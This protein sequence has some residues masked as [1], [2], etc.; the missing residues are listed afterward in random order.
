MKRSG[1]YAAHVVMVFEHRPR[2]A[3]NLEGWENVFLIRAAT[4]AAARKR[5]IALGRADEGDI[6]IDGKPGRCA[7]AGVRKLVT[8][9]VDHTGELRDGDEATY[10]TVRFSNRRELG[11]FLKNQ[12]ARLVS[13]D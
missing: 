7:F 10:S 4:P 11:R 6:E 1:W 13:L 12:P 9:L 3:T 8:C 5:A 2:R